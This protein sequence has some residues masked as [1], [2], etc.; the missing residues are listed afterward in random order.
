M[1]VN[2]RDETPSPISNSTEMVNYQHKVITKKKCLL[3]IGLGL[4]VSD[5]QYAH[6]NDNIIIDPP[7]FTPFDRNG[8]S[9]AM[10]E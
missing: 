4:R 10:Y 9:P 1:V 5:T 6:D 2:P 8:L 7:I 3:G